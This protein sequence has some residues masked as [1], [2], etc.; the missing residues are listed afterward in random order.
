MDIDL[1]CAGCPRPSTRKP[2]TWAQ[3][4]GHAACLS[5]L[6]RDTVMGGE[7]HLLDRPPV[8]GA[9]YS[10]IVRHPFRGRIGSSQWVLFEPATPWRDGW[11]GNAHRLQELGIAR[12]ELLG[13]MGTSSARGGAKQQSGWLRA[14]VQELV[15]A[16][17]LRR[18]FPSRREGTLGP[19][20]QGCWPAEETAVVERGALVLYERP[21][22]SEIGMWA[23]LRRPNL[24]PPSLLAVGE[25]G[26]HE[27]AFRVGNRPLSPEE[28]ARFPSASAGPV[29]R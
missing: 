10:I 13:F 2:P 26:F 25:W 12:I 18:A 19:S 7:V 24:G 15:L 4:S 22:T 3:V 8:I 29:R 1:S 14:R 16:P 28:A 5:W 23:L 6:S 27:A 21:L 9:T 20:L 17:D 11:E